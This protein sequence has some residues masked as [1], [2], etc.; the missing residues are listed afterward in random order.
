M[1]TRCRF[2]FKNA[3]KAKSSSKYF[4]TNKPSVQRF[5]SASAFHKAAQY[6]ETSSLIC[7][8][9]SLSTSSYAIINLLHNTIASGETVL[10]KNI[11]L[12][13]LQNQVGNLRLNSR[14]HG[15]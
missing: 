10:G 1:C 2:F 5:E 3:Q 4:S 14:E 8:V 6:A 9:N 7:R 13:P 15:G 11:F 12:F